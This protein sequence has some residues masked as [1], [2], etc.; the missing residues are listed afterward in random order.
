MFLIVIIGRLFVIL[1]DGFLV[2]SVFAVGVAFVLLTVALVFVVVLV[3]PLK[4]VDLLDDGSVLGLRHHDAVAI[5]GALD[6][7][8]GEDSMLT[9]DGPFPGLEDGV[10]LCAGSLVDD[11]PCIVYGVPSLLCELLA[12]TRLMDWFYSFFRIYTIRLRNW[13]RFISFR[14]ILIFIFYF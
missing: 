10:V 1:L 12:R 6:F 5:L 11:S 9:D 3:L 8:L 2:V 13:L 7:H 4:F 14:A